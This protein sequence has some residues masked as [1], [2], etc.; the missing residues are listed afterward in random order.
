MATT[1]SW[2]KGLFASDRSGVEGRVGSEWV[3][4]EDVSE[5]GEEMR[6]VTRDKREDS[7]RGTCHAG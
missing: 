7:H 1:L 2:L 6:D 4:T 3:L 5:L